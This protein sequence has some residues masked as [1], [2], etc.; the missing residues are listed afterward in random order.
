MQRAIFSLL[1]CLVMCIALAG[2]K[3]SPIIIPNLALKWETDSIF[4]TVESVLYDAKSQY[5]YTANIDG[6]FMKKDGQGSIGRMR[7]DGTQVQADWV[8][9]LNAPTGLCIKGQRLYTTD[10]D[11]VVSI[12]LSSGKVIARI[13][14]EGAE[15][16][17]DICIDTH[18]TLYC[19]DTGGNKVFQLKKGKSSILIDSID[20]PN[21]LMLK[22]RK[23]LITQ[24]TPRSLTEYDLDSRKRQRLAGGIPWIDGLDAIPDAGWITASWGG[25]LHHISPTGEKTM[26]L[27]T[28]EEGLQAPDIS[29]IPATN[30]LLVATFDGDKIRAY[31]V[32][33]IPKIIKP[34]PLD[35]AYLSG[36]GLKKVTSS[37]DPE[38]LLFQK[39]LFQGEDISVFIVASET[40]TANWEDYSIEEFIYVINGRARLKPSTAAERFYYPGDFFWVP[41]GYKGEWE[42]QGGSSFYHELSVIANERDNSTHKDPTPHLMDK[43]LIAGLNLTPEADQ[44][45]SFYDVL[46]KGKDLTIYTQSESPQTLQDFENPTEQLIYIIAGALTLEPEGGESMNFQTGD[47]FVLPKGFVG[48]W[49]SEGHQL[50][51]TL[52]V[53]KTR[54]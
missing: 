26:I 24:W 46:Q 33:F 44:T 2:Q 30:T 29:Y 35:P 22:D 31:D 47:F 5:I 12:D 54:P 39:M 9:G 41:K 40:K 21:G 50:F 17:N 11:E 14:I 4:P 45:N 16:L 7:A 37:A 13:S 18:G 52:R 32:D 25:L 19:S 1:L 27:D 42:T 34:I 3:R 48:T 49:Q 43:A 53:E 15:A 8:T 51:R 23:L 10:I 6:H 38:R 36:L 20:T 28:R